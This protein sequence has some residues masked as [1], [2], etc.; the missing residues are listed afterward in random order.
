[1]KTEPRNIEMLQPKV[2]NVILL[3]SF[4]FSLSSLYFCKSKL[5]GP[6]I[7]HNLSLGAYGSE[8]TTWNAS[9]IFFQDLARTLPDRSFFFNATFNSTFLSFHI[10][11]FQT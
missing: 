7:N 9:L 2:L 8:T 10:A 5:V 1:M 6:Y 3:G 11:S 4:F